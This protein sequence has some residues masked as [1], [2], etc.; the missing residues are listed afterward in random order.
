MPDRFRIPPQ[1]HARRF[2]DE[3]VVLHLGAGK[4]FALDAVGATIWDEL[5]QGKSAEEV[6]HSLVAAYEVE[7]TMA[8][9]D[10]L[11]LTG[12]LLSEGLLERQ[13]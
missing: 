6:A 8:M 3:L 11:R 1:V 4:Y 7:G 10:V 2:D 5:A 12:E 13:H 9:A